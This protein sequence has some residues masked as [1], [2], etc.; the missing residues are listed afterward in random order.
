MS[1]SYSIEGGWESR[2]TDVNLD[3]CNV[4]ATRKPRGAKGDHVDL[5]KTGNQ[6]SENSGKV[7]GEMKTGRILNL[8]WE[9]E[10]VTFLAPQ[11]CLVFKQSITSLSVS[12]G[13]LGLFSSDKKAIIFDA[14]EGEVRREFTEHVGEIYRARLFPSGIVGLT[15]GSDMQLKIWSAKD[16]K[17][18]VT[19]KGHT[20]AVNDT[21][22]LEKGKNI[23]S[24]SKDGCL[25]IW[26]CASSSCIGSI[27]TNEMLNC[28]CVLD[29]KH[30]ESADAGNSQRLE[31]PL[32]N[33]LGLTGSEHGTVFF[34]I[35][36]NKKIVHRYTCNS[37][38][39]IVAPSFNHESVYIGCESGELLE[40]DARNPGSL[41]Y[42]IH[43]S[44]SP[45][46]ALL[47]IG[48][49]LVLCGR[50]DGTCTLYNKNSTYQKVL[51]GPDYERITGISKDDQ[52]IYTG[53]RD[54]VVR[55]YR[56]VNLL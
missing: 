54:G 25:K 24:C 19:L 20:K 11:K 49:G 50:Q 13:G 38:V 32:E 29:L 27:E 46:T 30:K 9:G 4:W 23:I 7:T 52:Y 8:T 14:Q 51:S 31:D 5:Q 18:P 47:A 1:V 17:C 22:F 37:A 26:N 35:L 15:T 40:L 34:I 2:L 33:K 56:T 53:S 6:V 41:V 21:D 44:N 45:V 48:D 42:S 39:N 28:C 10:Q 12:S 43:A 55:K 3:P 36:Q 16:G